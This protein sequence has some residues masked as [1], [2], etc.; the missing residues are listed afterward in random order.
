MLTDYLTGKILISIFM[1]LAAAGDIRRRQI[2][3]SLLLTAGISIVLMYMIVLACGRKTDW[4]MI[5]AGLALGIFLAALSRLLHG[6]VGMGDAVYFMIVGTACGGNAAALVF[7]G[8]LILCAAVSVFLI[9][10]ASLSGKSI[11]SRKL[12]FLAFCVIPG[13]LAVWGFH[14][15]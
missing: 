5:A 12:P 4:M 7:A 13:L 2:R 14:I 1:L 6:A 11:R 10:R 15:S 3:I 9:V 8:G